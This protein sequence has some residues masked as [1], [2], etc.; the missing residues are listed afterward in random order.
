MGP[1]GLL[2]AT[3]TLPGPFFFCSNHRLPAHWHFS[4]SEYRRFYYPE[5]KKK[6]ISSIAKNW[7]VGWAILDY[8]RGSEGSTLGISEKPVAPAQ[9]P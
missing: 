6:M 7:K 9:A 1:S 5:N 4:K 2:L 8:N 3:I